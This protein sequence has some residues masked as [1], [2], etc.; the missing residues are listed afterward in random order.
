MKAIVLK[1]FGGIEN[2]AIQNIPTPT[3]N[4]NEVLVRVK[5]ISINPVDIKTRQG[6][7]QAPQFK[8]DHPIILGWDISGEI[9]E[10]GDTVTK[11]KVGDEVFGM[12][13]FSGVGRAYAEYVAAPEAHLALKPQNISHTEAAATTLA[14][15]TAWQAFDSFGK[16]RP[17][18]KILI[19]AASGGVG[20]FAVQIAKHL[21]AYVIG[22]SS[23]ANKN[24]ILSLGAD[25]HIDYKMVHFEEAVN[26]IDFILE[27]IGGANFQKSV[28]VL[29][30]FG[31]IVTL[32]SGH[33]QADEA[34]AKLK[35]LHACYFMAVY[36]SGHDMNIIAE[37]LEKGIVKPHI[38]HTYGF[39]EVAEAHLQ[40]E[41]G[42]T[43][44]KIVIEV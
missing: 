29:K 2:L 35:Q 24:F 26:D 38:S 37:L 10:I 20:H 44:G 1:N 17:T 40:I 21:G 16:L 30:P 42:R 14:A 9:T 13:N 19:H 36:S 33:T 5:A 6:G 8:S 27:T 43:V 7:A 25:E 34:A 3:I 31:T 41:S 18:D 32:P 28:Q 11:F 39:D 4:K 22:T 23:A 15:L 12:I